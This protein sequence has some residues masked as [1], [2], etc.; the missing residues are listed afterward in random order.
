M[1][2]A[3]HIF[4]LPSYVW[5]P[6]PLSMTNSS[7]EPGYPPYFERNYYI[8]YEV[9]RMLV[10]KRVI[11][12]E[13]TVNQHVEGASVVGIQ[14]VRLW[15][16][17]KKFGNLTLKTPK[18]GYLI[19][20]NNFAKFYE[21]LTG[22]DSFIED[23]YLDCLIVN[24]TSQYF[25]YKEEEYRKKIK[26]IE[27]KI[28]S[29]DV[30]LTTLHFPNSKESLAMTPEERNQEIRENES[31]RTK[32]EK[33]LAHYSYALFNYRKKWIGYMEMKKRGL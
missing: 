20:K 28:D 29:I 4:E 26:K 3:N 7:W 25:D 27:K 5:E 17:E 32:L 1:D 31:E 13:K 6:F 12:R 22:G 11:R 33:R 15:L 8:T 10:K 16:R 9:A 21:E 2:T 23:D 19:P 30:F 18:Y 24:S 14:Q